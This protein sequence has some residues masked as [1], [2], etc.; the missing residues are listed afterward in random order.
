MNTHQCKHER[1]ESLESECSI[2]A[3]WVSKGQFV[4]PA[5][6]RKWEGA[7]FFFSPEFNFYCRYLKGGRKGIQ[8]KRRGFVGSVLSPAVL[9]TDV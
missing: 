5:R 2:T 7:L 4:M 9:G 3:G 8:S 6:C 1:R